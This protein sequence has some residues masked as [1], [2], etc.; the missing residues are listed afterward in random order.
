MT[1]LSYNAFIDGIEQDTFEV[2]F[3]E[4]GELFQVTLNMSAAFW[5]KV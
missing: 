4:G 5:M 2:R 1:L 3:R